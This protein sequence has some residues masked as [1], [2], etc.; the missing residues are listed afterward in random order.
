MLKPSWI[1]AEVATLMIV[2]CAATPAVS[3]LHSQRDAVHAAG[4]R[5]AAAASIPSAQAAQRTPPTKV[6]VVVEEN[7]SFSQMRARMPYLRSLTKKYAFANNYHAI[8]YPSLPNYLALVGGST[9]KVRDDYPPSAHRIQKSNVFDQALRKSKSAKTYAESMPARCSL[10]SSGDYAVRHNPWT[11]FAQ[12]RSRCNRYDVPLGRPKRG[13]LHRDIARGTLPN[14]GLIVPNLCHDA[15]NCSLAIADGWLKRWLPRV[16]SG[17]DFTSGRL[18]VVVT[19]DES[20]RKSKN[21]VLTVVMHAGMTHRVVTKRLNHY[22][23][24]GYVDHVLGVRLLGHAT[25]GF[26]RAFRL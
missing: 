12:S 5:R 9:F 13:T 11:Y 14:V 25:R 4:A 16:L 22:S 23:L 17:R 2:G 20:D 7:H 18:T 24:L 8:T 6:L 21:D 26:A 15:H 1:S 3:S 19:A 10:T